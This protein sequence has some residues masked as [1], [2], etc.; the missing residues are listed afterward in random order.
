MRRVVARRGAA[1][2]RAGAAVKAAA[3]AV[4]VVA[5]AGCTNA[6]P[7]PLVTTEIA[8]TETSRVVDPG[9]VV[10]G[11][12]SVDGGLNPHKLSDQSTLTTSLA[13]VLL[14]SVFRTGPDGVRRLDRT[15]MVSA[16]VT[17]AEPYVVT[18]R[19]RQEAAW[20]DSAP[21]AAED[22]VYLWEQLR[23]S[24]GSV[25]G[26]GYRLIENI[27][28][29][30]GGKV[31]EVTFA[32]P[33]PG[34]RSLFSDL[35]PAHLLKDS[36]GGWGGALADGYPASGGPYSLRQLDRDRGEVVLER[37]DRYWTEP[38]AL[39]RI[40]LRRTDAAGL[41][42]ALRTGHTQLGLL[43]VDAEGE[44]LVDGLG[45]EVVTTPVPGSTVATVLL[46]PVS[47]AMR[48]SAVRRAVVAVLDRAELVEVGTGGGPA[49]QLL[50]DALITPPSAPGYRA[51][52]PSDVP[53]KPDPALA[54][55]LLTSAGY[56][57]E[58]GMWERAGT[59]LNLT[60]AAGREDYTDLAAEVQRQLSVAGI[61]SRVLTPADPYD[62][63]QETVDL[64]VGPL[65]AGGDL[66]VALAGRFGCAGEAEAGATP[67]PT[68]SSTPPGD[69]P[70]PVAA[71][72]LGYCDKGVDESVKAALTGA[73]PAAE[74]LASVE[75][76]LWQAALVY[77][78]YQES[79]QL[80]VHRSVTGVAAGPPLAGPFALADEWKRQS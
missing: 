65:P 63:D 19:V 35:L 74:V 45:A 29:R 62:P 37:N 67:T 16:E 66:A 5:V 68:T 40:V 47:E 6:P 70:E 20:S 41:V 33:Y 60:I 50:A 4:A 44:A 58:S 13:Q 61:Q 30:E 8:R 22:F 77:P 52:R 23:E 14:P 78:L 51:T 48:Q 73:T 72:P 76:R 57:E 49:G 59:P 80:V 17:T 7:P 56:T 18:Y 71:N 32:Q 24:P 28:A 15:V 27:S 21:I 31:V 39:D 12:G 25:D 11:V 26:A 55:Q 34:W 46:R 42:G 3:A 1:R 10:V 79:S 53:V 54:R 43:P 75:P 9:E 69:T 38:V 64:L 2:R 36:P